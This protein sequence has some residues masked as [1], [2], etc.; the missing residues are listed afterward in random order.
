MNSSPKAAW[1]QKMTLTMGRTR[2]QS[3]FFVLLDTEIRY[4]KDEHAAVPNNIWSL[5]DVSRVQQIPMMGYRYCLSLDPVAV[6][7]S[8]SRGG[9]KKTHRKPL[10]L[11]FTSAIEMHTWLGCIQNRLDRLITSSSS[12]SSSNTLAVPQA[13]TSSSSSLS[14]RRGVILSSLDIKQYTV[15]PTLVSPSTSTSSLLS[16]SSTLSS[17]HSSIWPMMTHSSSQKTYHHLIND[18]TNDDQDETSS[19]TFLQYKSQFHLST[20]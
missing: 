10:I 14:R 20:V 4:Y 13:S 2:W 15:L 1:L 19:P 18:D 6:T 3:R 8:Y 11:G 5:R 9:T 17:A 16:S 7:T 12:S